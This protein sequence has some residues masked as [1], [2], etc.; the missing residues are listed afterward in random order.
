MKS[1]RSDT[2]RVVPLVIF[3]AFLLLVVVVGAPAGRYGDPAPRVTF[4]GT[5]YQLWGDLPFDG[6][7]LTLAGTV[8]EAPQGLARTTSVYEIDRIA[9]SDAIAMEH[10]DGRAFLLFTREGAQHIPGLCLYIAS[11]RPTCPPRGVVA[12]AFG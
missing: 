3:I 10:P 7:A 6:Q 4:G 12:P 2:K 9:I 11:A 5:A 1:R 8:A